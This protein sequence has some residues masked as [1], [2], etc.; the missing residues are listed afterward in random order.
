MSVNSFNKKQRRQGSRLLKILTV[1]KANVPRKQVVLK[2]KHL[3]TLTTV[4]SSAKHT[5]P[6]SNNILDFCE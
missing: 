4:A 1:G 6:I 2:N 5:I 3:Y